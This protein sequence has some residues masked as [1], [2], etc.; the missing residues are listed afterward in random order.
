MSEIIL[1]LGYWSVRLPATHDLRLELYSDRKLQRV[2]QY[3]QVTIVHE[4]YT[5]M[6]ALDTNPRMRVLIQVSAYSLCSSVHACQRKLN[7]RCS[8]VDNGS[9]QAYMYMKVKI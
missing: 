4:C 9:P 6:L 1:A 2:R 8:F 7:A 5:T 3:A